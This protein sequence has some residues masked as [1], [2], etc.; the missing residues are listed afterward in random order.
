MHE[1]GYT[2]GTFDLVHQGHFDFLKKCKLYCERLIVGLVSDQLG[3]RQKRKPVLSYEH[4]KSI[5]ENCKYVDIVVKF[6]GA[7]K[8][9]DLEKL[10]FDIL[11]ISDEYQNTS[12]YDS[13]SQYRRKIPV[14][15]FPRSVDVSSTDVYKKILT[16]II[17]NIEIKAKAISGD[18]LALEWKKGEEFII[19]PVRISSR[20]I[21]NTANNYQLTIPP[22][23]NWKIK[24]LNG[25]QCPFISGVN[26]NREIVI[27]DLLKN[28]SWYPVLK[29]EKKF[30]DKISLKSNLNGIELM[31]E[32]R[33]YSEHIYWLIQRDGGQTLDLFLTDKDRKEKDV[34]YLKIKSIIKEM[35]KIGILHMD[36]H[37]HNILCNIK[38]EITIIDFGWVM[39]KYFDMEDKEKYYYNKCLLE[40]FDLYHFRESLVFTGL[41]KEV[42]QCLV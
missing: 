33:K 29:I 17:S 24:G 41:E 9:K 30:G 21:N 5:L 19:K 13:F 3:E 15:Y 42:P 35:N 12:E 10:K 38:G 27:F 40:N 22:P 4:R 37:P 36:L 11:F 16:N 2:T 31:N 39:Y 25:D 32:E 34:I 7:S 14:L 28:K 26:G 6:D 23:R 1:I 20:E 18:I 8:L